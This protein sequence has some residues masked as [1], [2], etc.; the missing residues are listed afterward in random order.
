MYHSNMVTFYRI[1]RLSFL[2]SIGVWNIDLKYHK[3]E[4]ISYFKHLQ[5]NLLLKSLTLQFLDA[6]LDQEIDPF[7]KKAKRRCKQNMYIYDFTHSVYTTDDQTYCLP[8]V[9]G[10]VWSDWIHARSPI[11]NVNG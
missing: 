10:H 9:R 7:V 4:S 11:A 3:I 6:P 5:E 2:K 1:E 8:I